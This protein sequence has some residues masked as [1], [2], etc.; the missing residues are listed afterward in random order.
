MVGD[1]PLRAYG[2]RVQP[3]QSTGFRPRDV[4]DDV[5]FTFHYG[6]KLKQLEPKGVQT[7]SDARLLATQT[8]GPFFPYQLEAD[9]ENSP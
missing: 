5:G 4:Y 8:D 3:E 2:E 7:L 1:I 9:A 6:V